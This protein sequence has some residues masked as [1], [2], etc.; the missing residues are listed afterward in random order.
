M[1]TGTKPSEEVALF[2][3]IRELYF[4]YTH[5]RHKSYTHSYSHSRSHSFS[6]SNAC[7]AL[8]LLFFWQWEMPH[9]TFIWLLFLRLVCVS[10]FNFFCCSLAGAVFLFDSHA[11]ISN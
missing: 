9:S 11:N 6:P 4:V 7:V 3:F 2:R 10:D 1:S 8:L 5:Q